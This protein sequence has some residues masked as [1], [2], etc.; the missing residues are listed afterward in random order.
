MGGGEIHAWDIHAQDPLQ[1]KQRL[2]P[3]QSPLQTSSDTLCKAKLENPRS[4]P[5][6]NSE[7]AKL[8]RDVRCFRLKGG[9][10]D[11][12]RVHLFSVACG[13]SQRRFRNLFIFPVVA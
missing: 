8:P 12:K 9:G 6:D 5:H 4:L 10:G 13:M 3:T 2:N 11:A 1:A 7:G